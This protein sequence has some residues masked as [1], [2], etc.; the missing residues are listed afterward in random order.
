MEEHSKLDDPIGTT[1][2]PD[3]KFIQSDDAVSDADAE[4]NA[5]CRWKGRVYSPGGRICESRLVWVCNS[6]GNWQA[7][8]ER[9]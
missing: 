4:P 7:T 2:E 6:A 9:C 3:S 1:D 8:G 5:V